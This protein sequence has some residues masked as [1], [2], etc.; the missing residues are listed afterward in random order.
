MA[1]LEHGL[2]QT[3]R[4][5]RAAGRTR[6][7]DDHAQICG[8]VEACEVRLNIFGDRVQGRYAA[9]VRPDG[10]AAQLPLP[11]RRAAAYKG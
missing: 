1:S 7:A 5:K 8:V 11:E 6:A 3:A 4:E 9:R 2:L 10:H